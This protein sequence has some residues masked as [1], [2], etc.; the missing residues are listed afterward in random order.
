MVSAE[1]QI[2]ETRLS[3]L[4]PEQR[5]SVEQK[6]FPGGTS[7]S[8]LESTDPNKLAR[9]N[10][11]LVGITR[12]DFGD[13]PA[14]KREEKARQESQ[15]KAVAVTRSV[16]G[17]GTIT[18]TQ[19]GKVIRRDSDGRLVEQYQAGSD[20]AKSFVTQESAAIQRDRQRNLTQQRM[21][22]GSAQERV[23]VQGGREE[24]TAPTTLTSTKTQIN[25]SPSIFTPQ[26]QQSRE[27]TLSAFPRLQEAEDITSRSRGTATISQIQ[28]SG[29]L[30]PTTIAAIDEFK[31]NERLKSGSLEPEKRFTTTIKR[32]SRTKTFEETESQALVDPSDLTFYQKVDLATGGRLRGGIDKEFATS[33]REKEFALRSPE[34]NEISKERS[35]LIASSPFKVFTSKTQEEKEARLLLQRDVGKGVFAAGAAAAAVG[36]ALPL[37]V[38]GGIATL[39]V[40]KTTGG[41][42]TAGFGTATIL[43]GGLGVQ[44]ATRSIGTSELTQTQKEILS[45]QKG[46]KSIDLALET[47]LK[48]VEQRRV[49]LQ[50]RP[51]GKGTGFELGRTFGTG[52][53]KEKTFEFSSR[54]VLKEQGFKGGK[55]EEAV[56]LTKQKRTTENLADI[57]A[58]VA[59]QGGSELL[60]RNLVKSI[61]IGKKAV[62][63]V[64]N[65]IKPGS[66]AFKQLVK[67]GEQRLAIAGL[68]EGLATDVLLTRGK[69]D[70]SSK[71][72]FN[73][74][75]TAGITLGGGVSAAGLGGK[76]FEQSLNN[77]GKA[78]LGFSYA[79]DPGEAF[80]D[81][82]GDIAEGSLGKVGKVRVNTFTNTFTN[83]FNNVFTKSRTKTPTQSFSRSNTRTPTRTQTDINTRSV[84]EIKPATFT[85]IKSLTKPQTRSVSRSKSRVVVPTPAINN[86]LVQNLPQRRKTGISTRP[87]SNLPINTNTNLPIN[88]NTNL[89][90]NTNTNLPINTNTN[91]PVNPFVNTNINSNINTNINSNI[92]TNIGVPNFRVPFIPPPG[93]GSGR[94]FRRRRKAR[95]TT[96]YLPSVAAIALKIK[97]KKIGIGTGLEVRPIAF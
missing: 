51:S 39:A 20:A 64:I 56:A 19:S 29:Q 26:F 30:R 38:K 34:F 22:T 92:N 66:K 14:S 62:S 44:E 57:G 75:R 28:P 58:N 24:F 79:T 97:G 8:S 7:R 84:T 90:I 82:L 3:R 52:G 89:P 73:P 18:V 48:A 93:G 94:G 50:S 45:T 78:T 5:K 41:A 67:A 53:F 71:F 47:G 80:G 16:E 17:G 13:L 55:L 36:L 11:S 31:V 42:A 43:A 72:K 54:Q 83:T 4:N 32:G 33:V 35:L 59:V 65:Q 77:K 49:E 60:G 2:I 23:T 9:I 86:A 68:G 15:S 21:T 25:Q 91:L 46:R 96:T 70:I 27:R 6:F 95:R 61:S 74:L 10:Q 87:Q 76:I 12:K 63:P 1:V 85:D 37:A 81:F 40:L 88:T 69:G